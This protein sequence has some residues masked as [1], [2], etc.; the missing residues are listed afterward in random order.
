MYGK[1]TAEFSV[2]F[3][4]HLQY[5][6]ICSFFLSV[7]GMELRYHT[8]LYENSNTDSGEY[9]AVCYAAVWYIGAN[10]SEDPTSSVFRF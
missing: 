5:E 7:S 9:L 10:T 1:P 2:I 8:Q 3:L 4:V 6:I